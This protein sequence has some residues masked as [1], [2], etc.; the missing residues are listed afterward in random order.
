MN[1]VNTLTFTLVLDDEE[2][3]TLLRVLQQVLKEKRL[4]EH[5]S[6]AIAYRQAVE[7]EEHILEQLVD[8]V[9]AL[10]P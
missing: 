2:R 7:K 8:K 10:N 3:A 1:A 4:E 5:R 9:K 6:D